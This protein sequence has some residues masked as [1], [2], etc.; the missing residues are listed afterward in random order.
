MSDLSA[1]IAT[2]TLAGVKAQNEDTV[3]Y[4]IPTVSH[5]LEHKGIALVLADGV[6]S[7]EAG[8]EASRT[9]VN[10]FID[11]YFN[12]PDTWSVSHA[13]QKTL[14]SINLN[15]Y[16]RSHEFTQELKGYLC[17][18][19][20]LILKSTTGHYFHVGDSRLFH[21]RNGEMKQITVDH[22]AN[23]GGRSN[24]LARAVG[25]DSNLSIDYGNIALQEGDCFIITSDGFHDFVDMSALAE[26]LPESKDLQVL[27]DDWTNKALE[28]G[29]DDNISCA[30]CI[31]DELP[32]ET[33]DDLNKKLTRLP[34]PPSLEPG[35][36]IDGFRIER[37]LFASSRSQ[38]YLV[39]DM[40]TGDQMVMKTPSINFEDDTH[41]IDRFIQEE[42]IGKRIEDEHIVRII[43]QE[44]K[45]NFLYYLMEHVEGINLEKWMRKNPRPKPKDAI[46]IVTQIAQ[47]LN[48]FHIKETVHQD[49]K[50]GNII[51]TPEGKAV[52]VDFGSVFVAGI[53]EIFRIIEHDGALGTASYSDPHY[54]LGEN[55][56]IQGDIYALATIA[57]EL[58]TGTLP[59]GDKIENCQSRFDFDRLRY[60]PA[61]DRN[62]I[63]PNWFDRALEKGVKFDLELRYRSLDAML[64]DLTQPNPDFVRDDPRLEKDQSK[65]LFW[66]LM[67][68]FWIMMLVIFVILFSH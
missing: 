53:A 63:I 68:G 56:G 17:T 44:R 18:W 39:T 61:N 29:S 47:G 23:L 57:Y 8:K 10:Q 52:I 25:M 62:P 66:Q 4:R 49:L 42:W 16:K 9:A 3:G 20:G 14:T 51:I 64:K 15:L 21:I 33:L 45:R 35:M 5:Q 1:R 58:F 59:Y 67:S 37:E 6:S 48:A 28:N 13:G 32:K 55:S 24:S 38:L 11:D 54:I 34:F 60:I 31:V 50:P 40:E 22:V 2:S 30:L 27:A 65:L 26:V 7:A 12:T 41:Y 36:K 19:S 43:P 46:E